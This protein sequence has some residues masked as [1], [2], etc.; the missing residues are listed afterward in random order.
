MKYLK[1]YL[2]KFNENV[3]KSNITDIKETLKEILLPISDR[4]YKISVTDDVDFNGELTGLIIKVV[5]YTDP[6]LE[7]DDEVKDEFIRM[8]EYLESSGFNSVKAIYV[9]L[10]VTGGSYDRK[11]SGKV[12]FSEFINLTN[13]IYYGDFMSLVF[14]AKT[15]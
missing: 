8:K 13:H 4:G 10:T 1:S 9:D 15:N 7:M 5:D 3:D 14:V 6:I 2:K 11:P 12:D